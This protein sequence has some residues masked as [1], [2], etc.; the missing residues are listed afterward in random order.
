MDNRP[1]RIAAL[2]EKLALV[3]DA[4]HMATTD[5]CDRAWNEFER[6]LVER[7]LKC[8]P[9]DDLVRYRLS[10]GIEAAR[11]VRRAIEHEAKTETGLRKELD[12]LE[13]RKLAPVA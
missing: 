8:G 3:A 7:L 9:D 10:I 1:D 12:H 11:H 6:E 13:G 5:V 2:S 4:R